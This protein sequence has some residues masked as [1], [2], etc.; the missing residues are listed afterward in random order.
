L[1]KFFLTFFLLQSSPISKTLAAPTLDLFLARPCSETFATGE[2]TVF[3]LGASPINLRLP[4]LAMSIRRN[5]LFSHWTARM[6]VVSWFFV[7]ALFFVLFLRKCTNPTECRTATQLG[8]PWPTPPGEF[9]SRRLCGLPRFGFDVGQCFR[10]TFLSSRPGYVIM[11]R[12][13]SPRVLVSGKPKSEIRMT[14]TPTD[15]FPLHC[16][17]PGGVAPQHERI[18]CFTCEFFPSPQ[19]P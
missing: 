12:T 2:V 14:T 4:S 6:Y 10:P 15:F 9:S 7:E 3:E 16:L 8:S 19:V 11:S 18:S 1:A 17:L 13:Q 5:S